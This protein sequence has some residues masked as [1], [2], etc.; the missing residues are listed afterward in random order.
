M[1]TLT[2]KLEILSHINDDPDN[3]KFRE[4]GSTLLFL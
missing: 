4:R 2:E 3:G 1:C